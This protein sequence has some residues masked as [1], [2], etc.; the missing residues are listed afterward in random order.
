M[1]GLKRLYSERPDISG[2]TISLSQENRRYLL[3]VL[4]YGQGERFELLTPE[5]LYTCELVKA[6]RKEGVAAVESERPIL[7]PNYP[8][9][10]CQSILKR[11]YMDSAVEK[12]SELGATKIVPVISERGIR[13][14]S[15]KTLTRYRQ[16]A[17]SAALVSE[18]EFIAGI[19]EPVR[20]EEIEAIH[21]D[22]IL[23]YG[24]GSRSALKL[25]GSVVQFVIGPEG[26]FTPEEVG[27]LSRKGFTVVSPFP[28]ILKAETAGTVFCGMLR[29]LL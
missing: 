18:N 29:A 15:E 4:R 24:R 19:S 20:I 6:G 3:N 1:Y 5:T 17:V 9:I 16:I 7:R 12:Y 8:L 22:N 13:A 10:A 27:L 11:E 23:F 2:K 25:N 21:G 26:G 14:L 28:Q